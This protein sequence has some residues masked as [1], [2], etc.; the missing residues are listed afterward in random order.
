[1]NDLFIIGGGI[2]GAG[3]AAHASRRGLTVTLCEQADLASGT[4]WTSSKLIH[5]GLRYLEQYDF[6]L[7]RESLKERDVL[8][9]KAPH[10][11]SPLKF[12]MPHNPKQRPAWLIRL[13]LF[14]YDRLA[15][16]TGLKKSRQIKLQQGCDNP[17]K[18]QFQKAFEYYDARVDDARLVISNAIEAQTYG[19]EIHTRTKVIAANWQGDHWDITTEQDGQ[20][21]HHQ[22]RCL[23]N[24]AGPWVSAVNAELNKPDPH[25]IQKIKGSH[26]IVPSLY[27]GD[28]AYLLQH[29][30]GRVVFVIPF[31][32]N[33]HLIGTTDVAIEGD[34]A[35][36]DCSPE[37]IEYLLSLINDYFD[38]P[39]KAE[40]IIGHYSGVRAIY[41]EEDGS[42]AT[43]S[44]DYFLSWDKSTALLTVYGGKI[45]TYRRL[46]LAAMDKLSD[47][48]QFTAPAA[49]DK[50]QLPGA[51]DPADL[52]ARLQKKYPA[53]AE[54]LLRRFAKA[55]GS[56]CEL[57]LNGAKQMTDLGEDF[58][59]GL[60]AKE[61]DYLLEHEWA[62]ALE[63]ILWRRTKHAL[64]LTQDQQTRLASYIYS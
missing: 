42:P 57:I 7:V 5:G 34:P 62:H 4:S 48:F 18:A 41:D 53:I 20:Q 50:H 32:H 24:A 52:F 8:L 11:I 13:G 1:M 10:L 3:I 49:E 46:A 64:L 29:P 22:A 15:G 26:L 28:H 38:K 58:G 25:Q 37:E 16:R 51:C 45:T 36:A 27:E 21:A 12:I 14:I 30:D 33:S 55:Y 47:R 43:L 39:I 35:D 2:N 31:A 63:D 61:V 6:R 44:R 23:I 40:D 59:A 60:T 9:H 56:R 54:D 17:L 19:A